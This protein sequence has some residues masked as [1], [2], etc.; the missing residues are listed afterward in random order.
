MTDPDL[1]GAGVLVTRPGGQAAQLAAAV[2]AAGGNA[3]LFPVIDIV[4]RAADAVRAEAAELAP[5][6]VCIFVS[7]NAVEYGLEQAAGA[8]VAAIGPA[9]ADAIVA[10]G[11]RVDIRPR[12]GYDSEHLLAEPELADMQGKTVRIVRGD[13]GREL[14]AETLTRRGA[15]VQ[16]LCVYERRL[17]KV[18]AATREAL[19]K[20]FGAGDVDATVVMSVDSL[21]NLLALLPGDLEAALAWTIL[22][23]PSSRVLKVLMERFPACH[24]TLAT[25]PQA[26]DIVAALD[27]AL[28]QRREEQPG[29]PR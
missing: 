2:D 8:R 24:A 28:R 10:R 15:K 26:G 11:G 19:S 6:D 16:Y 9:T 20:Q 1:A 23:T 5:P 17:P 13:G 22:V 18:D 14:L 12:A 21:T 3:I 25:G 29:Q 4:A 27:A 7:R